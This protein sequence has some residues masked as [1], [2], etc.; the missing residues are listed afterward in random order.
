MLTGQAHLAQSVAE[1][2]MTRPGERVMR[3]L[4]GANLR[5]HL[6]E[7]IEP[8]LALAIYDD[9]VASINAWEPEYRMVDFQLVNLSLKG[10]LG[11]RHGGIY[12]PEG[13][14]GNKS[15]SEPFGTVSDLALYEGL[16]RRV[17]A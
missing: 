14:F 5:S 3:L 8:A 1:I 12:F 16:A 15:I 13:R 10:G 7:D 11:V 2:W 9:L 4:F 17:G 6:A